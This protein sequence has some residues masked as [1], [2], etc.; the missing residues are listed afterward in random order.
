M[1]IHSIFSI[2]KVFKVPERKSC[3]LELDIA[4]TLHKKTKGRDNENG[5]A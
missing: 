5:R 2:Y 3:A 4:G 1:R